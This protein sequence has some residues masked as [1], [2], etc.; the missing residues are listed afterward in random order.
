MEK[1]GRVSAHL[2]WRG[3][4]CGLLIMFA[5]SAISEWINTPAGLP[6]SA[7]SA[8]EVYREAI[9]ATWPIGRSELGHP[10]RSVFYEHVDVDT[11]RM[12]GP[13]GLIYNVAQYNF[14]NNH[15]RC[16]EN[17]T[18]M[19]DEEMADFFRAWTGVPEE[20]PLE[21]EE[22][23]ERQQE[24]EHEPEMRDNGIGGVGLW[25]WGVVIDVAAFIGSMIFR[26]GL[27]LMLIISSPSRP[28]VIVDESPF[29]NSA[30]SE[31]ACYLYLGATTAKYMFLGVIVAML[32]YVMDLVFCLFCGF[33]ATGLAAVFLDKDNGGADYARLGFF[34]RCCAGVALGIGAMRLGWQRTGDRETQKG[35][36]GGGGDKKRR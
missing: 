25:I 16:Y 13:L 33:A 30:M 26:A 1:Q 36:G 31:Y 12:R 28:T 9:E 24:Q 23:E 19:R 4:A 10:L 8:L 35:G 17:F 14:K 29:I 7:Q 3:L 15:T 21:E 6:I 22:E 5:S 18:P 27:L 11:Y 2:F 34:A 32:A 20:T